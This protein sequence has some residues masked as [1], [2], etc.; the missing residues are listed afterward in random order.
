[1]H[2]N[3]TIKY[4]LRFVAFILFFY[5]KY[6]ISI[7]C[8]STVE[9]RVV[10]GGHQPGVDGSQVSARPHEHRVHPRP[11]GWGEVCDRRARDVRGVEPRP[12][13]VDPERG[14]QLGRVVHVVLYGDARHRAG[15]QTPVGGEVAAPHPRG[16][17]GWR[18]APVDARPP[19][20]RRILARLRHPPEAAQRAPAERHPGRRG[21]VGPLPP[22]PGGGVA[23]RVLRRP[24]TDGRRRR[25]L[26]RP[27]LA[28]RA[29]TRVVCW[30]D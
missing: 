24:P 4:R 26:P 5:F 28:A 1:M 6:N 16:D 12:E 2:D 22:L 9:E 27:P 20:V 15:R 3:T 13:S 29:V 8:E 14:E 21:R 18:G 30:P 7:T 10:A 17:R 11:V 19:A 23:T 25:R